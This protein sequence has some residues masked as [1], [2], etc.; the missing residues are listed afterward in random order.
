MP[1]SSHGG[2][3]SNVVRLLPHAWGTIT[4]NYSASASGD[5]QTSSVC[6]EDIRQWLQLSGLSGS[7]GA[8]AGLSGYLSL[9]R[10]LLT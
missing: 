8:G 6:W 10:L 7:A 1:V 5:R 9:L 4:L 2:Q 3:C